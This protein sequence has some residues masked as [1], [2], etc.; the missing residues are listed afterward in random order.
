MVSPFSA[1]LAS[2]RGPLNAILRSQLVAGLATPRD[3]DDYL[4]A[5]DPTWSVRKI[6]ARVVEVRRET[7]SALSVLVRPNEN[8]CTF[9]AGQFVE[10]SVRAKGVRH[11]RCFSLSSAP[12][13]GMPL[14]LTIQATPGG[15]VSD[16]AANAECLGTVVELSRARGEFV[17]PKSLPPKLLFVSGGS[18]ITPVMSMLRH[19]VATGYDGDIAFLHYARHE[20]IFADELRALA[21]RSRRLRMGL[22]LT[23]DPDGRAAGT[24]LSSEGLS[25]FSPDWGERETFVCGPRG[26]IESITGLWRA[27]GLYERLHIEHF[28]VP[29][30]AAPMIARARCHL[31]FTR[32]DRETVGR[33]DI[34]LLEQAE[35]AGLRPAYGCRMGICHTCTCRMIS[36]T[37]RHQLTGTLTSGPNEAIQLCVSMPHSD[38]ALDL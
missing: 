12:E 26:M 17:L 38:V 34:S 30:R 4:E 3:V 27:R 24:R 18:G 11:T 19:L 35:A 37:V 13:D 31:V 28:A 14:R 21:S 23:R 32:S 29:V 7:S 16:W 20:V 25:A 22:F 8:W 36:G 10:L 5:V 2:A 6:R 9:R 33:T 15:R 1:A